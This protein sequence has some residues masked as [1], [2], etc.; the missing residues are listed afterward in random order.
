LRRLS[1]LANI[2][3]RAWSFVAGHFG[4]NQ[5]KY[6]VILTD[7]RTEFFEDDPDSTDVALR[8]NSEHGVLIIY[9]ELL[10]VP[11]GPHILA[12]YA[13]GTWKEVHML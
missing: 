12:M 10:V 13:P 7:G 9:E 1:D 11:V 6:E 4:D 5:L 2:R 3:P 8:I